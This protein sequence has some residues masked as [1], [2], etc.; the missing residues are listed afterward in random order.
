MQPQKSLK[1]EGYSHRTVKKEDK[2]NQGEVNI[3]LNYL[4]RFSLF[5]VDP[6]SH[7]PGFLEVQH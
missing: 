7:F 1:K 4:F 2:S 5:L 3:F 6:F